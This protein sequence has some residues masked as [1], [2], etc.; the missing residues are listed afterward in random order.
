MPAKSTAIAMAP[1]PALVPAENSNKVKSKSANMTN[2]NTGLVFNCYSLRRRMKA[3]RVGK[4]IR[5]ASVVYLGAVI[6]YLL[7][8]V[9]ELAG[10]CA[11]DNKRKIIKP[12]HV[13][14]AVEMDDELKPLFSDVIMPGS[15]VVPGV[16]TCLMGRRD[17]NTFRGWARQN[18]SKTQVG[19][20]E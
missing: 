12:R 16:H 14:M 7:A 1:T 5:P 20:K 8:E 2:K 3:S 15:G 9:L 19:V 11:R 13:M 17:Q 6:E 10:N 18:L 4:F